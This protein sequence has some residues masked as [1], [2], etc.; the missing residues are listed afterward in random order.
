MLSIVIPMY[1]E[2]GSIG[3]LSD[4]LIPILSGI[5]P[6]WEII[7]VNDGSS[8][9]T[10][11]ELKNWQAREPRIKF[12][13]LSRNFGKEAALSAGL[14]HAYGQAVIPLDA[15]L[16]DPPELIP[17]LVAKWKEGYK[18]V[19]ATRKTRKGDSM[20]KRMSAH[21]FY[22]L[23]RVMSDTPIPSNTGDFRLMDQQV[24]AVIRLLPE[25]GRFMKGLF[26]WVGFKTAQIHFDRPIRASGR[27][28][29]SVNKLYHLALDGLMA[30]STIPLQLATF[31]G[32][33][34][35]TLAFGYGAWLLIR[36]LIFGVD[37]AGY[38]SI[39]ASVLFMGGIQLIAIGIVGEYI[40]RVY[41]ESKQRPIYI[42]EEISG[43]N[44]RIAGQ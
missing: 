25:R 40:G 41:N 36:T 14:M 43:I 18:V 1:N 24:V 23:L 19:L 8:D 12:I 27:A 17:E 16:Q 4:C 39:M 29:Q 3:P 31:A 22:R 30:F 35:S 38:A 9:D 11:A 21:M 13:S 28:S 20:V 26:A 6:D 15:D 37:V 5:T 44:A 33:I 42:I 10:L 7:C 2:K 32:F 34:I